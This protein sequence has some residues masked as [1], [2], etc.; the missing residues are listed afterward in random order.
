MN[1]AIAVEETNPTA[2]KTTINEIKSTL[3]LAAIITTR[4]QINAEVNT[5]NE[6]AL[7]IDVG[8]RITAAK[9]IAKATANNTAPAHNT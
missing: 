4:M 5:S 1:L 3:P 8:P 9:I 6:I 7:S 2:D